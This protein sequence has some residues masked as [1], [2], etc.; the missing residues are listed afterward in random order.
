M[1]DIS[2]VGAHS[3][4]RVDVFGVERAATRLG[5]GAEARAVEGPSERPSDR[6]DISE[7]A[8]FLNKLSAM[9]AVRA[10]LIDR[11]RQEIAAGTYETEDRLE[12]AIDSM[13]D[14]LGS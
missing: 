7:R 2:L 10:E 13:I 1:A 4:E 12:Q 14:E 8:R 6:V 3:A 5:P 11:V 9:P